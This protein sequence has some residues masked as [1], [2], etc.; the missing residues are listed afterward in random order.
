MSG[1]FSVIGGRAARKDAPDKSTGKARYIEDLKFVGELAGAMLQ[2][3]QAHAKI[4]S[5]DISKAQAL[6]GVV[7]V[8]TAQ[9]VP[10]IKY[11]VSPARYDENLFA[12]D[13]VRYVGDEIA[14]VAAEDLAT[15]LK[16]VELIEV[17]YEPLPVLLTVEE[18][19]AEGSLD[20]RRISRQRLRQGGAGVWRRGGGL[21]RV[22]HHPGG[23]FL[24]QASGRG[25]YRAQPVRGPGGL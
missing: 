25:L 2:S 11:G 6:P 20:P 8:I 17:E 24:F 3:S 16:A 21:R 12:K 22:R 1:N 7:A 18:A 19:M 23:Q 9:D 5:I 15:A 14:A 4:K 13:R 10:D